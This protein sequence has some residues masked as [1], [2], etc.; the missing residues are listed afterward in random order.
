VLEEQLQDG[1]ARLKT[2][3]RLP[4]VLSLRHHFP[5]LTISFEV[6]LRQGTN[7]LNTRLLTPAEKVLKVF[8]LP[9]P[10][11]LPQPVRC[12]AEFIA[13]VNSDSFVRFELLGTTDISVIQFILSSNNSCVSVPPIELQYH[14]TQHKV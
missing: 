12:L 5:P 11:E 14:E 3:L 7:I 9:K 4:A 2:N 13:K 10:I 6:I 1:E 8:L